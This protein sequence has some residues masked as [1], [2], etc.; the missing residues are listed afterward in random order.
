MRKLSLNLS[1]GKFVF[2]L[3]VF[4]SVAT[5]AMPVFVQI[6]SPERERL[7]N[8]FLPYSDILPG[9][10]WN[11]GLKPLFSC[12]PSLSLPSPADVREEC[13][14]APLGGPFSSLHVTVWD[15]IVNRLDFTIRDHGLSQGDLSLLWG[16]PESAGCGR[17]MIW[18]WQAE[19][20]SVFGVSDMRACTYFTP[21]FQVALTLER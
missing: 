8:P 6:L 4:M 19:R 13:V 20:L 15:G 10:H 7:S 21:I 2:R 5:F 16:K 14:Y 9:Q 11:A 3:Y 18:K 12:Y 1:F 17:T